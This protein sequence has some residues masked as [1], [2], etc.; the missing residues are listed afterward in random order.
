MTE[1]IDPIQ[2]VINKFWE[3]VPPL[4][5]LVRSRIHQEAV[6]NFQITVSQFH[7]LRHIR[8][9]QHTVSDLAE[10]VRL[11]RPAVSRTVD[12]L[13]EKGLVGRTTDPHDRRQ[14]QLAL[15]P[16]GEDLLSALFGQ[17]RRWMAEHLSSL[18]QFELEEISQAL[19]MLQQAFDD[20]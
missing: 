5:R 12:S 19:A 14:I 6:E 3:V 15:T 9:G 1:Q 18:Q 17:V 2:L 16:A 13:V 20:N 10:T 8:A 4:W 7:V 11:S